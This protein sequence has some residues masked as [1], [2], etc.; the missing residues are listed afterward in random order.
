MKEVMPDV[1]IPLGAGTMLFASALMSKIQTGEEI[2]LLELAPHGMIA[3]V[4]V[5]L[6]YF[7]PRILN[8]VLEINKQKEKE[9]DNLTERLEN[10]KEKEIQ[11]IIKLMSD[12]KDSSIK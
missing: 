8:M 4:M 7:I 9:I 6:L 12:N 10:Q 1:I 3:V 5:L 2:D 11:R